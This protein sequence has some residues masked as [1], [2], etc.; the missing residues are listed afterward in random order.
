MARKQKIRWKKSNQFVK[1]TFEDFVEH[2]YN[3]NKPAPTTFKI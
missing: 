3:Q 1:P 2:M